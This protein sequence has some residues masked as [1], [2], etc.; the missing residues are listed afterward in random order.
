MGAG[1][2]NPEQR[3]TDSMQI[4]DLRQT[5]SRALEPLFLEEAA[6]W[7]KELY[8]DYRPSQ[9]LI[10][11]FIDVRAL[12]GYAAF[13][14]R[15]PAGY[16]FY[17]LEEGKGLIG[18]MFASPRF[19]QVA[20]TAK[21]FGEM[22]EA[23]RATPFIERVEAQLMPF[24]ASLDSVLAEQKFRLHRRQFMHLDLAKTSRAS[25]AL[26]DGMRLERWNDRLLE[27][28]ARLIQR[29]YVDH[30]DSEINDQYRSESGATRFLRNIVLLPGCG[31]FL[32]EASFVV[33]PGPG[34]KPIGM[35]LTSTVAPGVAHTTQICILP[36]YQ[37]NGLGR[38]LMEASL[39]VL[40]EMGYRALTLTVTSMNDRAML[41]YE[42]LGFK[43]I[44][45]FAAGV[46]EP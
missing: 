25:A 35:V 41:L 37:G 19:Q 17:V 36:G 20:I 31:Q 12:A 1:R 46:W 27:P 32:A 22:L 18:G 42:N 9:Q 45:T 2:Y 10:R 24:G 16:G 33:R 34:E 30:I 21:L 26:R 5:Q 28:C 15:Q 23:L 40:L 7:S 8:W 13:E 6:C 11:K 3:D 43:T 14:D 39:K 38:R 44:K 29:A 4:V